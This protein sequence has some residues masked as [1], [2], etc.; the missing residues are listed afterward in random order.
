MSANTPAK[1]EALNESIKFEYDGESYT[2]APA[3]EWD[4]EAL[5]AFEDQKIITCVRMIL[6]D[7]QWK[8]FK[9]K[10]RNMGD[11]NGLFMT[12]QAQLVG[13]SGN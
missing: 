12:M 9:S 3:A 7:D 11:L 6:G 10:P 13:P 8:R 1:A 4:V 2:V 5:E